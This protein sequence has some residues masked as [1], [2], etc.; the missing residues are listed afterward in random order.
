MIRSITKLAFGTVYATVNLTRSFATTTPVAAAT[1]ATE[2]MSDI[3]ASSAIVEPNAKQKFLVVKNK[4]VSPDSNILTIKFE[5]RDY[6]GWN[7]YIPTCIS[8]IYKDDTETLKKSYSPISHPMQKDTFDLL[9]KAYPKCPGGGVGAYL[10]GLEAG[11]VFEGSVKSERIMHKSPEILNRWDH[12]GLIGGGTGT[13]L[14]NFLFQKYYVI[15][16][17][18]SPKNL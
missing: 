18:S 9:V 11:D 1:T 8:A 10:C 13:I 14:Y 12:V 15:C 16:D 17:F 3:L 7:P 2:T 5:G 4:K 6:L